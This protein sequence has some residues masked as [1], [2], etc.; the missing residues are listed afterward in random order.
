[1]VK[2]IT[3]PIA[4]FGYVPHQAGEPI[5]LPVFCALLSEEGFMYCDTW[6]EVVALVED[7]MR[8]CYST[9]VKLC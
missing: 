5:R 7:T 2:L 4:R 6:N 8:G 9:T 3:Y 1:M